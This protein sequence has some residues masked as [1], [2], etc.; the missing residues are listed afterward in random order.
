MIQS[1]YNASKNPLIIATRGSDLALVQSRWVAASLAELGVESTLLILRTQGDREQ[2]LSF[3]KME[4]KGFFTKE[5][6]EALLRGDADIAVHSLKDL[7]T[8]SPAGLSV[9]AISLREDPRECLLVRRDMVALQYGVLPVPPGAVIGT[10]AA[11]RQGQISALRPDV[12]TRELRGNVPTRV[13]KLREGH[14]D[15]IVVAY[16]G[17]K[18]L[19][20]PLDD[21]HVQILDVNDFVPAPAQGALG[22]QIRSDDARVAQLVQGL[23]DTDGATCVA[24]ERALLARFDGGC[25]L[26]FGAH[27]RVRAGQHDE[28]L[29]MLGFL[30]TTAQTD[31][32][33]SATIPAL[34][35]RSVRVTAAD[36][37]TLVNRAYHALTVTQ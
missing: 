31:Q 13:R 7:P 15:A 1:Q 17:L 35:H 18:R 10:S 34:H 4:G 12:S 26:P 32:E 37:T 14:Y 28:P 30:R 3:D 24:A 2:I 19:N 20:L 23:H 25:H 36:A 27:A 29:E 11:R 9:A 16:A 8:E 6:E 33:H 22:I 21:L 5:L